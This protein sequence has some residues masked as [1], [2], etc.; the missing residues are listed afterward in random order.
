MC[1][2]APAGR[3]VSGIADSQPCFAAVSGAADKQSCFGSVAG[4]C[5]ARASAD[6][7]RAG[8]RW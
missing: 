5:H 2:V 3:A 7:Q 4:R 1:T 6:Y 8:Q